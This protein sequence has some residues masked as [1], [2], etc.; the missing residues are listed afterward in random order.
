MKHLLNF[1]Y[2]LISFSIIIGCKK[3]ISIPESIETNQAQNNAS[4]TPFPF[5]WETADYM[6]TPPG[7]PILVPWASGSNKNFPV[8]IAFDFKK[9]DGWELVYNTFNTTALT[10]PSYFALYNRY[11][12]LLRYYLYLFPSTP[13]ASTYVNHG[14]NISG[15]AT[16]HMLNYIGQDIVEINTKLR[17]T[18]GIQN[19]QLQSTGGWY[20]MQYEIAY[21]PS[22][23][24]TSYQALNFQWYSKSINITALN[25]S[26]SINGTMTGS[27]TQP[28]STPNIGGTIN[29][30][31]KG[32]FELLAKSALTAGGTGL[33]P[34]QADKLLEGINSSSSGIVKNIFSA[35]FGGSSGSTQ[36][37]TL[38]LNA[39]IGLS[40]SSTS[41]TSLAD[42]G[43]VIP[44][45]QD[46]LTSPGFTP[47]YNNPMG[48]FYLSAKPKIKIVDVVSGGGV[49]VPG[50]FGAQGVPHRHTYTIDNTSFSV[51]YNPSVINSLAVGA[52]ILNFKQE[53]TLIEPAP[54][55]NSFNIPSAVT[56]DGVVE[57]VGNYTDVRANLTNSVRYQIFY[58]GPGGAGIPFHQS[59]GKLGIRFSFDVVPNNGAP[60][61]KVIKTFWADELYL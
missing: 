61:A 44:G 1:F 11:R 46:G 32:V 56:S 53:I 26:G 18:T 55:F 59:H 15:S 54:Y 40:G 60:A 10:S 39:Q 45:L 42:I 50:G 6:P 2:L 17:S 48:V 21:D 57:Q 37:I 23:S 31:V 12:G 20:I 19:Y 8:D 30:T 5:S 7:T 25:L 29:S 9:S 24:S 49:S 16:P 58:G 22:I 13:T 33:L 41:S 51:L 3:N 38:S 34:F 47:G 28:G 14:I 35:I 43:L 52:Q 27:I 4:I 36:Q